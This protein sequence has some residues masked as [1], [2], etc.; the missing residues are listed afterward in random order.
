M[1]LT[2]SLL[3]LPLRIYVLAQSTSEYG[4]ILPKKPQLQATSRLGCVIG[5]T[6]AAFAVRVA[7]IYALGMEAWSTPSYADKL[8]KHDSTWSGTIAKDLA[9]VG[10][11]ALLVSACL[12]KRADAIGKYTAEM[13]KYNAALDKYIATGIRPIP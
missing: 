12:T 1:A 6:T 3:H 11:H 10:T 5:D 7:L 2:I 4:I 9:S 13:E 8:H